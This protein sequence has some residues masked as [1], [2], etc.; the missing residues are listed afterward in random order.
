M[1]KRAAAPWSCGLFLLL[2]VAPPAVAEDRFD[3]DETYQVAPDGTIEL[4]TRDAD[5][6]IVGSQRDDVHVEIRWRRTL[7][8][9]GVVQGDFEVEI[10]RSGGNLS[11]RE[12]PRDRSV[13]AVGMLNTTYEV[14]I[15]APAGVS[16]DLRGDDDDYDISDI[17]GRIALEADDGNIR[18]R[19]CGGDEFDLTFKDGELEMDGGSGA[20]RL[21]YD[22][23]R[24]DLRGVT[25]RDI[26]MKGNDGS[27]RL[28]GDLGGDGRYAF[29][30]DDGSMDLD[31]GDGGGDFSFVYADGRLELK[32]GAGT[33]DVRYD[34]GRAVLID[35]R[36]ERLRVDAQDG[37]LDFDAFVPPGARYEIRLDDGDVTFSPRRGRE[38]ESGGTIT[39]RFDDGRVRAGADVR[40]VSEDEHQ[41]TYQ[42]GDGDAGVDI[43]VADGGIRLTAP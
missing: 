11:I 4:S 6:T 18:L 35:S 7:T 22:D 19:Q 9:L 31:V 42:W 15:Q 41:A 14:R 27:L 33:A 36:F 3:L 2:A 25:F 1:M 43:Y 34:D 37:S 24:A 8:G 5:V 12:V 38:A 40:L 23:G 21:Q 16:L 29:E 26:R 13:M 39:T 28:R 30:L 32:G 10:T 17:N 20:L